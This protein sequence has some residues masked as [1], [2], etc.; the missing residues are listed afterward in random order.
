MDWLKISELNFVPIK[1]TKGHIGF[2]S[3]IINDLIYVSSIAVHTRPD[4]SIRLVYPR[5]RNLDVFHPIN[6]EFG[7]AIENAVGKQVM[8]FYY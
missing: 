6:R 5:I 7:V 1:P 8:S 3:F 2:V 4:G